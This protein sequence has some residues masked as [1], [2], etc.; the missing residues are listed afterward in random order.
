M[1]FIMEETTRFQVV[2]SENI[3]E[4]I[5]MIAHTLKQVDHSAHS[6]LFLSIIKLFLQVV[7][8][9]L[10]LLLVLAFTL[11]CVGCL[12]FHMILQHIPSSYIVV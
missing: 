11:A 8:C 10:Y 9:Y 3:H 2:L 6:D 4:I 5:Q 1:A 12:L 7:I